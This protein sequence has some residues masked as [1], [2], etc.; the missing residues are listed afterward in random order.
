MAE[1]TAPAPSI[2]R[3]KRVRFDESPPDPPKQ[4]KD[5][6]ESPKSLA[7]SSILRFSETLQS[8]LGTIFNNL[9]K[10]SIY[11][12]AKYRTKTDQLIKMKE[13]NDFIPCSAR[14]NEFNFYI[15]KQVEED[16]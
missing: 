1:E 3:N 5:K 12:I 2:Q 13:D 7:L 6:M 4:P 9:A 16:A 8:D 10:E 15:L 14:I 11:I